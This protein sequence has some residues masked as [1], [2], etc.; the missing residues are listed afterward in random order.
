MDIKDYNDNVSFK[1]IVYSIKLIPKT[2][3]LIKNINKK[4]FYLIILFSVIMG[5]SPILT[6]ISSQSLLNAVSTKN[7]NMVIYFLIFY[8]CANLFSE[9]ISSFLEFYQ[10]KFQSLISYKLNY[11]VMEKC[12]KLSLK[13]FEDSE[14]YDKLQRV[15]NE[16]AY[17]PYEVFLSIL[18]IATAVVTLVSSVI[19]ILNWKPWVLIILVLIPAVFSF[20][21]LK[22]GQREFNIGWERASDKRKSWYLSYLL[23]KD[24]TFKEI[25][26]YNLGEYILNKFKVINKRFITEDIKLF[27]RRTIFTFIFEVVEQ[28]CISAILIIIVYSAFIGEILIGNVVGLINALN[29]IASN[30]KKILNTVYSL[31]QNN[32]YIKQLLEF[33]DLDEEVEIENLS[34]ISKMEKSEDDIKINYIKNIKIKNLTFSYP[35]NPKVVLNNINLEINKG[36]RVAIVGRNG[37]GKSTLVKLLLKLYAIDGEGIYYNDKSINKYKSKD[38]RRCIATLFQDFVKYELTLRENIAFGD[39]EEINNDNTI[40][41]VLKK[42]GI[43]YVSGLDTQLGLWFEDGVQLSGGQ[44]QKIAIA[45]ALFRNAS[46]YVLDEPSSALDPISEKEIIN[47]FMKMTENKIGIFISHRLSTAMLADKI[48]VMDDGEIV[49]IGTHNDLMKTNEIYKTMYELESLQ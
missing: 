18:N 8:I 14:I 45:R 22:I 40:E 27:K 7:I 38:I 15:Q 29:L 36:E 26:L 2:I 6:L 5:I 46:L 34:E 47:M 9:V 43:D 25:K 13:Q 42:I 30:C 32:L 41:E 3:K 33:L 21:F 39:I 37:S 48:V 11:K 49:G 10:S 31:Y 20:Y 17:K 35:T 4:N 28:I 44:W 16:T 24:N 1:D 12:T 19:I 23:T